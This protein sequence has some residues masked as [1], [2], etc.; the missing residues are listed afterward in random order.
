MHS[1][2]AS[3]PPDVADREA[4]EARMADEFD[5]SVS[6]AKAIKQWLVIAL[7]AEGTYDSAKKEPFINFLREML[8]SICTSQDSLVEATAWRLAIGFKLSGSNHESIRSIAK[9]LGV[10][11]SY[12]SR[13]QLALQD[14]N[15]L[16][17][18][19]FSKSAAAR[20][21]Y[22]IT[23]G[24]GRSASDKMDAHPTVEPLPMIKRL[25]GRC[26]NLF[27][28]VQR[29]VELKCESTWQNLLTAP[30][31]WPSYF[32]R[33]MQVANVDSVDEFAAGVSEHNR[34]L[35]TARLVR[36]QAVREDSM[37]E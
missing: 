16:P 11:A 36:A 31:P 15:G 27:Y 18:G 1:W 35:Q 26:P 29:H 9:E 32:T 10:T 28:K 6:L 17:L 34:R 12:L 19:V 22:M 13:R 2:D 21:K 7:D 3:M 33:L 8:C 14:K 23:N 30:M 20:A 25:L 24:K 4:T 5:I 37:H